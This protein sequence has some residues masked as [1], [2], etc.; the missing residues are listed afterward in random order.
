MKAG[1]FALYAI[2]LIIVGAF[3]LIVFKPVANILLDTVFSWIPEWYNFVQDMSLFDKKNILMATLVSFFILTLIVPVVEEFYF[4]GFLMA[5]MSWMGVSSVL[6]NVALFSIYHFYQP[7]M[8]ITRFVAMLP[9]YYFVY[10]KKSLKLG[11]VVHAFGNFIDVV[12]YIML[13]L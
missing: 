9:L 5:R 4:R 1:Q 10:K 7:W 11:I 13:L 3:F 12:A 8:I 2:V 6:L